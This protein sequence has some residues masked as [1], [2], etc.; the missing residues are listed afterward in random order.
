[1]AAKTKLGRK[2][3]KHGTCKNRPCQK[4]YVEVNRALR[5]KVRRAQR[6][7]DRYG[8]VI[9]VRDRRF[10][11]MVKVVPKKRKAA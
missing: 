1:M 9:L 10:N 6:R 2:S 7:A 3:R 5:N 4:R 11:E 8:I